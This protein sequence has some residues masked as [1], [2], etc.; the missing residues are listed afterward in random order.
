MINRLGLPIIINF[1][2]YHNVEYNV[3]LARA[4]ED[5]AKQEQVAIGI[6]VPATEIEFIKENTDLAVFSEHIDYYLPGAHTGS[7]LPEDIKYY[8]AQGTLLNHSERKLTLEAIEKAIKSCKGLGLKTV[9]CA[10]NVE[11]AKAIDVLNPDIIAIEPPELIG[12]DI[13]VSKAKPEIIQEAVKN[14]KNDI[15][16]GAGVKDSN[17]VYNAFR[18]GAKGVLLASGITQAEN[19]KKVLMELIQGYKK[20]INENP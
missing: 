7:I 14:I 2:T 5:V 12:G 11:E 10:A 19:P 6:A 3:K 1:K 8:G 9:V 17:D 15:I 20:F 4:L 16:V 13:S 18:L